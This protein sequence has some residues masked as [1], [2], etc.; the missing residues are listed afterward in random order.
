MANGTRANM[1]FLIL[2]YWTRLVNY[3]LSRERE[4]VFDLFEESSLV[5]TI[6]RNAISP[7]DILLLKMNVKVFLFVFLNIPSIDSINNI[8]YSHIEELH[9][10]IREYSKALPVLRSYAT[11]SYTAKYLSCLR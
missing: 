1:V 9:Q 10:E 11:V 8:N 4:K 7:F 6:N 5:F 3:M 2:Y